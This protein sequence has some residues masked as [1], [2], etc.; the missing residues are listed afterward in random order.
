[1]AMKSAFGYVSL[2]TG[3]I[4]VGWLTL[5]SSRNDSVLNEFS[6]IEKMLGVYVPTKSSLHGYIL[7]N[8]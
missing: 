6:F 3:S 2:Q 4:I 5:V 1:M 8:H 7:K